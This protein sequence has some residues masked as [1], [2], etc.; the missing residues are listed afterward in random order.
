M[1]RP[2]LSPG[3]RKDETDDRLALSYD[4]L[5]ISGTL[6]ALAI[7][8]R[9]SAINMACASLSITH[10]PA[11]RNSGAFA[12]NAI[13]PMEKLTGDLAPADSMERITSS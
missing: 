11:I 7:S 1:Q 6:T 2:S 5:K 8:L 3:P 4:A 13:F 12:P 9:P 10:G